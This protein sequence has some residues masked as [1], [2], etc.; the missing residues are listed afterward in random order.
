MISVGILA[1]DPKWESQL[2]QK[3]HDLPITIIGRMIDNSDGLPSIAQSIQSSDLMSIPEKTVHYLEI[4]EAAIRRSQQVVFGFGPSYFPEHAERFLAL[5]TEANVQIQLG[6]SHRFNP[7][8]RSIQEKIKNPQYIQILHYIDTVLKKSTQPGLVHQL[9]Q[10]IDIIRTLVGE[11]IKKI[12]AHTAHL[13]EEFAG[14][15][16]IRMEFHNATVAGI[17][18]NELEVEDK[19]SLKLYD[20]SAVYL[21]DLLENTV[22]VKKFDKDVVRTNGKSQVMSTPEIQCA[23]CRASETFTCETH[24]LISFVNHHFAKQASVS[25]IPS[26]CETLRLTESIMQKIPVIA[27]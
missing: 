4:A 3:G 18:L 11:R 25:G 15:I 21:F 12:Q 5:A 26:S 20:H 17:T 8:L 27:L 7:V 24:E 16:N 23:E 19:H 14:L 2:A 9:Y 22:R 1:N 13:T 10:D 6:Q